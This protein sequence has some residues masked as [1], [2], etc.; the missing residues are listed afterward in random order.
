[1]N[2]VNLEATLAKF[3]LK[4]AQLNALDYASSM[5]FWD[6]S[7]GAPKSGVEARS[8]AI[9]VLSG[10]YH[11]ISTDLEFKETLDALARHESELTEVQCALRKHFKKEYDKIS[12]IPAPEY[13]AFQSHIS[14]SAMVWE[15]AKENSD[16]EHFKP[17]LETTVET[18]KKFASY[19][20]YDGHPYNLYIDDFEPGMTVAQLD[21]FFE[22]L[23]S[24][25]V[26]LLNQIKLK[27]KPDNSILKL[28]YKIDKQ[29][30]MAEMLLDRIG[31][32]RKRG[33]FKESVHPFTMGVSIDDVRLTSHFYET[34]LLSAMLSTVHEGG[35]GIYEQNVDH[36]FSGT[37]L[38]T[39]ASNAFHESQSRI[40]E[41]NFFKSDAFMAFLFP[42]L[43]SKYPENLENTAFE[44]FFKAVNRVEPSL[45][46][47]EADELTYALHILVR[48]E[49]ELALISGTQSVAE[50]PKAWY[51]K[52]EQ[53]LG[54]VPT[55]DGEGVLQDVHWSEALFGYFPTYALGSAYAAQLC[56]YMK[57][58]INVDECLRKGD[59]T[60]I[61]KWLNENV[62]QY[63]AL[64]EPTVLIEKITG[65]RLNANYYCDYLEQKYKKLYAL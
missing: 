52:M 31:F 20:G 35:H 53:Y 65:E 55:N 14:K 41:N 56:Y 34:D 32:D 27:E 43:Q 64:Y 28:T 17:Y 51:D 45:I 19:R 36:I 3:D 39:G 8:R 26:P 16:F 49:L 46:R 33:M 62:H 60:P 6:A 25:L 18:L 4:I 9:G 58:E 11:T 57:K 15:E 10:F 5:M 29:K 2:T 50:L 1:M 7:T 23:K 22:T 61:T 40:Y 48:Y 63:G 21:A 24:R 42:I 12:K 38:A 13:E 30:E 44:M 54:V 47:I 59:F 37:P